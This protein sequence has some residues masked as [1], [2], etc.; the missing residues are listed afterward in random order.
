MDIVKMYY[1]HYRWEYCGDD[2]YILAPYS[3]TLKRFYPESKGGE[4]ECH[5][6]LRDGTE[7]VGVAQCSLKDNFCYRIGREIALGRALKKYA[8]WLEQ[9]SN[10]K[11]DWFYTMT[12]TE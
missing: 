9:V 1:K 6:V 5:L 3:R 4:T 12:C 8:D 2:N 11:A 10:Q 7:I